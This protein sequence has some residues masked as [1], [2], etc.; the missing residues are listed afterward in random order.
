MSSNPIERRNFIKLLAAGIGSTLLPIRSLADLPVASEAPGPVKF[1]LGQSDWVLH[2]DGTFDL[3]S[4]SIRLRNCRPTIDGQSIF[5][6]NT[7]MGDSPKGKRI[8]YELVGNS[9]VMLDLK[10]FNGSVSIGIE[11]SNMSRAPFYLSPLGE[12]RVEGVDRYFKQGLGQGGPSGI[13]KIPTPTAED[14]GNTSGEQAWSFDSYVTTA[15]LSPQNET[16]AF[17][18]YEHY[19]FIQKSTIYNRPH[20][21]GLYDRYPDKEDIFFETGFVMENIPLQNEFIKLPDIYIVKGNTP[22]DTLQHIAWNISENMVARKDTKTSYHWNSWYEYQHDFSFE[23]LK[24]VLQGLDDIKPKIPLQTIQIDDCY[25]TLG[26]WLETNE[27]WPKSM[28]DPAREIFQRG[29]RAG[30]WV[31]PFVVD[32]NSKLFKNHPNW[33]IRDLDGE[34]I[35][36]H[37][38]RDSKLYALDGSHPEVQKYIARVFRTF[39]KMGYTFF[40]TAYL[41]WG[42]KDAA[43]IR[44]YDR[45]KTSV[46]ILVDVMKIIREE[47]GAG[48]YWMAS[49]APFGPLIGF[50]DG[51]RI[52]ANVDADWTPGGIGNMFQ[53][54]YNC[55]YFNNVYWQNDPD[56]IFLRDVNNNLTAEEKASI[57]LWDGIMGGTVN[58]S[59]RFSTLTEE[60]LNLWRFLQPQDRPQSAVTP[61]WSYRDTG[62][63][64]VRRYKSERAWGVLIVNDTEEKLEETYKLVDLTGEDK[65]WLFRWTPGNSIGLG[66]M[67]QVQ[68]T[69]NPHESILLYA[70]ENN[71]DPPSDLSISGVKL[72]KYLRK[73]N[74]ID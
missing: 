4:G 33:L 37:N 62:K 70:S 55:Q 19:D 65:C 20:R 26:D 27:R 30:I 18:A 67:E 9:F 36:Q 41:S 15:L 14:W 50:V 2:S 46:Q 53:E 32:E 22:F 58:T 29:F 44:R 74:L 73:H 13:Y 28:E 31:A 61:L 3:V 11:L 40:K 52:S 71:D 54:S 35:Q 7:F 34:P 21:K 60:Q 59:D 17:S 66:H 43:N 23:Q 51:M 64:A 24:E 68:I 38:F 10:I 1:K 25:C 39:R 16:L 5:V 69:L 49:N 45:D 63:I 57:A 42:L 47:I 56:T 6:Q 48:A 8:I 12:A 72:E